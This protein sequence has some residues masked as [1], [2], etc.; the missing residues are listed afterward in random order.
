MCFKRKT[1]FVSKEDKKRELLYAIRV[2]LHVMASQIR[3]F[4]E[5][6]PEDNIDSENLSGKLIELS[7]IPEKILDEEFNISF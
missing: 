6:Y 7:F 4:N 5:K 2:Q 1:K 3:E